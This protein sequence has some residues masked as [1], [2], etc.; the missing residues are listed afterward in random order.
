MFV[1][2]LYCG[3][4]MHA[5][6]ADPGIYKEPLRGNLAHLSWTI[7]ELANSNYVRSPEYC[8]SLTRRT[9]PKRRAGVDESPT[10]REYNT[11][12][13]AFADGSDS[14]MQYGL[15]QIK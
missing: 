15:E 5:T 3:D 12:L 1:E 7:R 9:Y 13:D 4:P 11:I 14:I 8:I 2:G 10:N 6:N